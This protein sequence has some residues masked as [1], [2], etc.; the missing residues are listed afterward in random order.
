MRPT[1]WRRST[2]MLLAL[3]VLVLVTVVV[4]VTAVLAIGSDSDAQ[5]A[6]P[7]PP[8][9]TAK[10][11]VVPVSESAPTPTNAG[12]AAALAPALADPN[13][14]NLAGR[15]TD[16]ITGDRLWEQRAGV[17]MQP[18]STNKMLTAAAAVDAGP[19]RPADHH[20]G[21]R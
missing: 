11:A 5:A 16:A 1:G 21:G 6:K 18:A 19:R 4:A 7:Q 8:P 2:H 20:G 3:A 15:V 10:P 12:L 14:G 17:P 9:A 13:L